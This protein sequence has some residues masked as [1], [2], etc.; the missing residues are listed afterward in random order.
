MRPNINFGQLYYTVP[1]SREFFSQKIVRFEKANVCSSTTITLLHRAQ[2]YSRRYSPEDAIHSSE[3][4]FRAADMITAIVKA[5][6][7]HDELTRC[8]GVM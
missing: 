2:M 7:N 4:A 5:L 3:I 6:T 1:I 8:P